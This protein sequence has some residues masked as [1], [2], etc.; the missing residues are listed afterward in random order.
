M[1]R[2]S[3]L[4]DRAAE[5]ERLTQEASDTGKQT[6]FRMLR[7]MWIALANESSSMSSQMLAKEIAAIDELQATII[8]SPEIS[9]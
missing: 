1:S 6:A 3:E 7:E 5:C 8:G 9:K 2:Q 4:F